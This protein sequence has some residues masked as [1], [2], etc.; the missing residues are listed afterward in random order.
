MSIVK[1][2]SV[3]AGDMFYIDHNTDNFTTIDCCY[4]D[5]ESK[6]ANFA[7]IKKLAEAKGI[8]RFIS[9]HPDEDHIKGLVDF[10][11]Q[12]GITNFYCVENKAIKGGETD[13]FKKYCELR[14]SSKAYYVERGCERK[15]LNLPGSERHGSGIN[16]LWPIVS[17]EDFKKA[18][19][20]VKEGTAYNNISPVFTYSIKDGAKFLWMGDMEKDFLEKVKDY[21]EWS[22][23][24]IL[25][26]PHHGRK[27]GKVLE[28]VLNQLKPKIVVLGEASS[29][30]LDYYSGYNTITQ[31]SAG[32][33]VFW[34]D[35]DFVHVYVES[36]TYTVDFLQDKS[37]GHS[38]Y[39][40]YI[41]SLPV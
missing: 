4:A 6:S 22:E 1:S 15:W 30:D 10:C 25:F 11:K 37:K 35:G 40:Y 38:K 23:I 16:F 2:F 21:I 14:D 34:C 7:E 3:G 29:E 28:D 12:I 19:E 39:G 5:E 26:A 27:S 33:I 17:N 41:G 24:D 8:T 36:D 32:D 13:N 18:L 9:T 31:N 20:K